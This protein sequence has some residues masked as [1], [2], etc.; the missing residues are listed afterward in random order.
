[1]QPFGSE[2]VRSLS[3]TAEELCFLHFRLRSV[4]LAQKL[5]LGEKKRK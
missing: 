1:M 5:Y 3:D 4:E 2:G